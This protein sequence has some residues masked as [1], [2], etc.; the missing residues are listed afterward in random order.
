MTRATARTTA[1]RLAAARLAAGSLAVGTILAMSAT[2]ASA[3]TA[4]TAANPK[5]GSSV[6]SPSQIVL[7]YTETVR[8][9]RVILTDASGKQHQAG[10]AKA[11]DNKVTQP[12]TG[13]LPNGK[14]TVGWRVVSVDG[15]PVSGSYKFTVEGSSAGSAASPGAASSQPAA[16]APSPSNAASSEDSGGGSS[17]WLWIGLIALVVAAAAGAVAWF[18][19]SPASDG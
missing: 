19:R 18:R 4:L 17:G 3:H 14:Y 6:A 7:T 2:P 9:P 15:H 8:L 5:K 1:G 10:T 11:V 16:P 13:A 12:V